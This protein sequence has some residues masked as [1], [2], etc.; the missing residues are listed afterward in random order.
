LDKDTPNWE[1]KRKRKETRKAQLK[2][3]LGE[4]CKPAARRR[5]GMM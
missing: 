1:D 4:I 5:G 3:K 2:Q